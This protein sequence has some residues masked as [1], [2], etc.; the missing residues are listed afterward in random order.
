VIVRCDYYDNS[1]SD[2]KC[3]ALVIGVLPSSDG[4]RNRHRRADRQ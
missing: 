1:N 2:P 3:L 4:R